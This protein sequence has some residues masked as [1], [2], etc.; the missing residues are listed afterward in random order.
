M[1]GSKSILD[2]RL[3]ARSRAATFLATVCGVMVMVLFVPGCPGNQPQTCTADADCDNELYC[4][5]A[6]VC[7]DGVCADGTAPCTGD[8]PLCDEDTDSCVQC[9]SDDD[10]DAVDACT[11]AACNDDGTCV[12]ESACTDDGAFCTGE[13][14]CDEATGEC[15]SAGDPCDE[16]QTCIETSDSCANNCTAADEC[17]DSNACTV[18]TC[19]EGVCLSTAVDCNDDDNC[20]TD[21]CDPATGCVNEAVT[22]DSGETCNPESGECEAVPCTTDADCTDDGVF[23]NGDETCDTTAGTCTSSGDPCDEGFTCNEDTDECDNNNP[24]DDFTLTLGQDN[25]TG[26]AGES[27]FT[28]PLVFNAPTGTNIAS[29]QTFDNLDGGAGDDTLTSTVAFTGATTL[30]PTMV[31]LEAVNFTDFG[32]T[33]ATTFSGANATGITAIGVTSSISDQA[34]IFNNLK[35]IVSLALSNANVGAALSFVTAATTGTTDTFAV[36]LSN[37]NAT[38]NSAQSDLNV[39]TGATNGFETL[40]VASEG[41]A[42]TLRAITQTTGTSLRTLTATG[43]QNLTVTNALPATLTTLNASAATGAVTLVN[44]ATSG[45]VAFTGGTGNDDVTYAGSYT[46]ADVINGGTGT[47]ILGLNSAEAAAATNQTNVTNTETIR[48]QNALANDLTLS[49]FGATN[50]TLA[51]GTGGAQAVTLATNGTIEIRTNATAHQLT[52][53]PA[54]DTTADVLNFSLRGVNHGGNLVATSFETL[55]IST[56]TAAVSI[57]GTVSLANTA[58]SE[59]VAITGSQN[60][61][62]G[63]AVDADAINASAFT[64][65]LTISTAPARAVQVTGGSGADTLI[66]G[67]GGD[68]IN[69][70][71]GN[72]VINGGAG[73]DQLSGGNGN[74]TYRFDTSVTS[75]VVS[76]WVDGQD[77][78]GIS[79]GNTFAAGGA[80]GLAQG[81]GAAGSLAATAAGAVV[82][83]TVA[84]NAAAAAIGTT[85]VIKLTTAVANAGT[86]Q[87]TFNAAIGTAT[88]T[89]A[90]A[91][92]SYAGV[93]FDSTNNQCVL[94]EVLST[95][96]TTTIIETGDVIRVIAKIS[97]TSTD[98]ANLTTADV[99]VY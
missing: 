71:D 84:Q 86:D 78:I 39:T 70:G 38:V 65:V 81:G 64:G 74:D 88:L 2:S 51:G 69:G 45:A 48:I 22:C 46:T 62:L 27:T 94:F 15:V 18:D 14:S 1:L 58:A 92:T 7:T 37:V 23:C 96:G 43:S 66:G 41:A 21:A 10:C 73:S 79:E 6:E 32:N 60:L 47:D 31:N 77:L 63:G 57:T 90:T 4:D 99:V 8:T 33:A 85:Q 87:T 67:T 30:A 95:A 54:A 42:N 12:S 11:E 98:F 29:L 49:R 82:V 44:D 26:G 75:D 91:A 16:N 52:V 76:A 55:N 68:I 36:T 72:D 40:T 28:A 50:L 89:G 59:T 5:G 34:M 83:T 93:Y 24:S 3:L 19:T 80:T 9:D 35:G 97:M 56:A 20:T 61:T 25:F 17:D 53:N 13:E